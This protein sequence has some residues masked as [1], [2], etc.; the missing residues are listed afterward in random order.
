MPGGG[1]APPSIPTIPS[2]PSPNPTPPPPPMDADSPL[3]SSATDGM[4]GGM[5]EG[6]VLSEGWGAVA[7][8][9]AQ[10]TPALHATAHA[11]CR[12]HSQSSS[13]GPAPPRP[14]ISSCR[15]PTGQLPTQLQYQRTT[16]TVQ[17]QCALRGRATRNFN[18]S[19]VDRIKT[20]RDR[21]T[22]GGILGGRSQWTCSQI[23][24]HCGPPRH[25]TR[26]PVPRLPCRRC[27]RPAVGAV[28]RKDDGL[29]TTDP[30]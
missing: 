18:R 1:G 29:R 25:P 10:S 19:G 14:A 11:R 9:N 16:S 23:C 7:L 21:T 6:G 27:Q 20:R 2:G 15:P 8:G 3:S 12:Q 13:P 4:G 26:L 30:L 22:L 24:L 5:G 28:G 17:P